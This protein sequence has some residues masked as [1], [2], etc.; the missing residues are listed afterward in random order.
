MVIEVSWRVFKT[1]YNTG[2]KLLGRCIYGQH[3]VLVGGKI[4]LYGGYGSGIGTVNQFY[5]LDLSTRTW[6]DVSLPLGARSLHSMNLVDDKVYIHGGGKAHF[7]QFDIVTSALEDIEE[8][9]DRNVSVQMTTR[10]GNSMEFHERTNMLLMFGGNASHTVLAFNVESKKW[11]M[12]DAKG[13]PP[14]P[15]SRHSTCIAGDEMYI[16]GGM[17]EIGIGYF[18]DLF[19]LSILP[20]PTWSM[21]IEHHGVRRF[22]ASISYVCGRLVIYGGKSSNGHLRESGGLTLFNPR[23]KRGFEEPEKVVVQKRVE[24]RLFH[25]AIVRGNEILMIGGN[26]NNAASSPKLGKISTLVLSL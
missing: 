10:W 14:L 15:R 4:L 13:T 7:D 21:L 24:S 17:H 11:K 12:L 19:V 1:Q 25:T 6:Q 8:R 16:Y 20:H 23:S 18:N 26:S 9:F 5:I 3:C 2:C 22:G